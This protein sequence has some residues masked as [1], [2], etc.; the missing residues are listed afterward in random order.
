VRPTQFLIYASDAA[1]P[2]LVDLAPGTDVAHACELLE[3]AHRLGI[4]IPL[5][6]RDPDTGQSTE[7]S[8]DGATLTGV[9]FVPPKDEFSD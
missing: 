4:A 2:K 1:E 5:R 9:G 6:V 8:I 7:L 3:N